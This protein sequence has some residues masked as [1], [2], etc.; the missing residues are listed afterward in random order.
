M[1][2]RIGTRMLLSATSMAIAALVEMQRLQAAQDYG[3]VEKP[4]VTV[5]ISVSWL[6]PQYVLFGLADVVEM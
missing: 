4:N 2:Q 1:L 6:V 3:L 5:P